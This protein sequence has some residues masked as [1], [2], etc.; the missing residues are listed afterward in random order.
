M[1]FS[2]S[3]HVSERKHSLS[4]QLPDSDNEAQTKGLRPDNVIVSD[5]PTLTEGRFAGLAQFTHGRLTRP[6]ALTRATALSLGLLLLA[7]CFDSVPD[8]FPPGSRLPDGGFVDMVCGD[9]G[10]Y[11]ISFE[12]VGTERV[13]QERCTHVAGSLQL[14]FERSLRPYGA[15][16]VVEKQLTLRYLTGVSDLRALSAL[17]R[18]NGLQV[19]T[20]PQLQSLA[21][22]EQLRLMVDGGLVFLSNA[23]LE[24]LSALRDCEIIGGPLRIARHDSL[25]SLDGLQ[26]VSRLSELAIVGNP[27]LR[28]L[29]GLSGLQRV[30]GDVEF[31]RNASLPRSEIDRFLSR[32]QVGGQTRISP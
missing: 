30:D 27:L 12:S 22:L 18:I 11:G 5:R 24:S 6:Q 31:D 2:N 7:A 1:P 25:R 14:Q 9:G 10:T 28:D 13:F 8:Q 23:K 15:V 17:Q 19:D 3:A 4:L 29:S 21:G 20:L 16:R 26:R 32:V